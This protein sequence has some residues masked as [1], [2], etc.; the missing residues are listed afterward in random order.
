[1]FEIQLI[2]KALFLKEIP[3]M[4]FLASL[5]TSFAALTAA[6]L[7]AF[8][9]LVICPALLPGGKIL[10]KKASEKLILL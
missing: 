2:N 6:F 7:A 1:M 5:A 4:R 10:K 8:L 9:A 3:L